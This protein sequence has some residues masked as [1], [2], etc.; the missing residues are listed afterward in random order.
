[1]SIHYLMIYDLQ[2]IFS[3]MRMRSM[4]IFNFL[5]RKTSKIITSSS[6]TMEERIRLHCFDKDSVLFLK[7]KYV[8]VFLVSV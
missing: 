8:G 7:A 6:N 5:R 2:S 4:L 3:L 1:M